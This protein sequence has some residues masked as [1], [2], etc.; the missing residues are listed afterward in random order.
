M[1]DLYFFTI[2]L[3]ISIIHFNFEKLYT[4]MKKSIQL[5]D[6]KVKWHLQTLPKCY[7]RFVPSADID[8]KTRYYNTE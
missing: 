2:A 6:C 4:K 3:T 1:I 5:Y 8:S 7:I